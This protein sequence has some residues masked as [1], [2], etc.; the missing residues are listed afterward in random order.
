M[1]FILLVKGEEVSLL[2]KTGHNCVTD[3]S[4]CRRRNILRLTVQRQKG[5]PSYARE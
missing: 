5:E 3:Y 4:V 1:Y 2:P